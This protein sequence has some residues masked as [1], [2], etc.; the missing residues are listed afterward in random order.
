MPAS[1]VQAKA[2]VVDVAAATT[3]ATFDTA[4][5]AG[6]LLLLA[7]GSDAYATTGGGNRPESSGFALVTG[8]S[9]EGNLGHYLWWKKA[10]GGETSVS[11]TLSPAGT[12]SWITAEISGVGASPFLTSAGQKASTTLLSYTTPAVTPTAGSRLIVSTVGFS[13]HSSNSFTGIGTWLNGHAEIGEAFTTAAGV[14][15]DLIGLAMASV[16]ADGLTGYSSGATATMPSGTPQYATGI[17]AAFDIALPAPSW[18]TG[19]DVR[20]G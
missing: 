6:N 11:Y 13:C 8:G 12:A 20:I 17:T 1:L 2:G 4:A 5:V 3:A 19:Y 10:T 16:T 14:S 9:Q 7:V 15:H 18:T